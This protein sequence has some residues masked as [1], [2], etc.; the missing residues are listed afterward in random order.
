MAK[1]S[2]LGKGLGA[3]I[4]ESSTIETKPIK[5]AV[6]TGAIA[7]VDVEKIEINPFQPRTQFDEQALAELSDSIKELGIIQPI[8]LRKLAEN[9]FQLI[10][11]ERRLR[12]SKMAG[13][14]Q[15]PAYIRDANDQEMLEFALVENLQRENL[16]AIEIALSYQRLMDECQLTQEK[17][18]ERTG[19][20]RSTVANYL[21]LLNLPPELQAGLRAKKLSMGHAR[22][23]IAVSDPNE[24]IEIFYRVI[25]EDLN[26]RQT[27]EIVK[28]T[29]RP[30]TKKAKNT[31]K[32]LDE[33]Y[34]NFK[35]GLSNKF[36]TKVDLS[37]GNRGRG[38]LVINFKSEKELQ[39]I[40]EMMNENK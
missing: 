23:L 1:K 37:I 2:R 24:Q 14:K 26:V 7:K 27:E 36:N 38:K 31:K 11:G 25:N 9:K 28:Q 13:L 21:R 20:G 17:L 22:T 33:N 19:K 4:N 18:S 40:M 16:D 35:N 8:T 10:S 12:A 39:K 5:E 6:S 32:V 15:I 34:L 30:K 29:N 3:L